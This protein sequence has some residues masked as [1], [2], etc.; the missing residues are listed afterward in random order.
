[1]LGVQ[2]YKGM[3][4][5]SQAAPVDRRRVR[6]DRSRAAVLARALQMASV[7]GLGGITMGQLAADLRVSKGNL[8]VLFGGKESLQLA[9]LDAARERI[10]ERVVNPGL[11]S[12]SPLARLKALCEAWFEYVE[13]REFAGGCLM[14]ATAHEYRAQRGPLH[15]TA[16]RNLDEWRRLLGRQIQDAKA[17]GE[18]DRAVDT[19]DAVIVLSSYQNMAHLAKT[20]HDEA[21]YERT[22]QLCKTYIDGLSGKVRRGSHALP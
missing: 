9:T 8:T 5:R 11:K 17:A 19:R 1:M 18:I 12:Q 2:A 10:I 7:E 4:N 3:K 13:R 14:Y 15:E 20:T 16:V 21:T 22:R 6:G